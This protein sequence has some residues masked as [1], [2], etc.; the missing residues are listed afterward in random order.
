MRAA[1]ENFDGRVVESGFRVELAGLGEHEKED[2]VRAQGSKEVR[3]RKWRVAREEV[4]SR[5]LKVKRESGKRKRKL[6]RRGAEDAVTRS[7]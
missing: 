1:H 2:E 6:K 4:D 5:Q 7:G 3:M